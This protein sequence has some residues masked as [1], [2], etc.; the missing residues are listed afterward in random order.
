MQH[1]LSVESCSYE[2]RVVSY[3]RRVSESSG[4]MSE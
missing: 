2:S 4:A 3:L 1:R